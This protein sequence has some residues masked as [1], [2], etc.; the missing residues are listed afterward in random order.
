MARSEFWEVLGPHKAHQV[1]LL[2]IVL[3]G[4][5][6]FQVS[7]LDYSQVDT[8]MSSDTSTFLSNYKTYWEAINQSINEGRFS[9]ES[10]RISLFVVFILVE[11][12]L[13]IALDSAQTDGT[14][15]VALTTY[16]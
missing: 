7:D 6:I 1:L 3:G 8:S 5:R 13:K 9:A 10:G 2:L 14:G 16:M 12:G 4:G 11:L 15:S